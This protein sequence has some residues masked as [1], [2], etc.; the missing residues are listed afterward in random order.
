MR[1]KQGLL[2]K[3]RKYKKRSSERRSCPLALRTP[4]LLLREEEIQGRYSIQLVY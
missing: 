3:K 2:K 4:R 1:L